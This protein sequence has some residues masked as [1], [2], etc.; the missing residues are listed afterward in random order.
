MLLF[1]FDWSP[2]RVG[3]FLLQRYT[4]FFIYKLFVGFLHVFISIFN[5]IKT[6]RLFRLSVFFA[7]FV[8]TEKHKIVMEKMLNQLKKLEHATTQE[9]KKSMQWKEAF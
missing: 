1:F 5:K 3:P 4:L 9:V 2:R 7:T 8:V 6:L